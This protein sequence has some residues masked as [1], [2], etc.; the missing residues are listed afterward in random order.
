MELSWRNLWVLVREANSKECFEL[1]VLFH[2]IN[3]GDLTP[4]VGLFWYFF[5]EMF[6]HFRTFF[7]WTFQVNS[8][9]FAIPLGISLRYSNWSVDS[10]SNSSYFADTTHMSFSTFC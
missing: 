6:D 10:I 9:I 8:F 5:T 1:N 4:N 7:L 2:R 3:V